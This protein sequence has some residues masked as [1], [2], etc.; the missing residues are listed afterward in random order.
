MKELTKLNYVFQ[1]AMTWLP[2]MWEM[3][4]IQSQTS[5]WFPWQ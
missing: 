3:K 1:S 5:A 2:G 4:A